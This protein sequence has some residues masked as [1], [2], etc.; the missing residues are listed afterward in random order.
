M[1]NEGLNSSRARRLETWKEVAGHFGVTV[2]TAQLWEAERGLPVHRQPGPK[3]RVWADPAELD[4]WRATAAGSAEVSRPQPAVRTTR[5]SWSWIA[6]G[7]AVAAGVLGAYGWMLRTQPPRVTSA[8]IR[9]AVLVAL[10]EEGRVL[11]KKT[12]PE[13]PMR[14]TSGGGVKPLVVETKDGAREVIFAVERDG[15]LGLSDYLM[16]FT[17]AGDLRWRI[18]MGKPVRADKAY[19]PAY[20]I[21]T[22]VAWR[23][24]S[25]ELAGYLVSSTH[26]PNWPCQIAWVSPEGKV[27]R[28]YWHSGHMHDLKVR[29]DA[30][31]QRYLLY[32][33]GLGNGTQGAELVILDP[34]KMEGASREE[35]AEYQIRDMAPGNEVARVV[36]NKSRLCREEGAVY[37]VAHNVMVRD[38]E[39]TVMTNEI[40]SLS[41]DQGAMISYTLGHDL[42]V[43]RVSLSDW[44]L[45]VWQRRYARKQ[46]SRLWDEA[47]RDRL[48]RV[49]YLVGGPPQ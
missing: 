37:N 34:E 46:V 30:S 10:D 22:M 1:P 47:E 26:M 12:Q 8:E 14:D 36:F 38:E 32:A 25:G 3:G 21:S 43:R 29:W 9:K 35:S 27:I 16:A 18:E 2:R 13:N 44:G 39:V 41:E 48:S 24:E 31:E 42:R 45:T 17:E 28:E 7:A 20:R 4:A 15:E 5:R 23:R 33:G 19:P 49:R 6:A 40:P 11:W